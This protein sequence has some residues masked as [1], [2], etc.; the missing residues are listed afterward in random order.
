M[1]ELVRNAVL[2]SVPP[3]T[4]DRFAFGENWNSFLTKLYES[5]IVEAEKA[6]QWLIGRERR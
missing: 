3:A 2:R 6:L 1:D 5:R 4:S